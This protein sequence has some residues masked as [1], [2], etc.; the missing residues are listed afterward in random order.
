MWDG[1]FYKF[2]L[3]KQRLFFVFL[4]LVCAVGNAQTRYFKCT[5]LSG[6]TYNWT[7]VGNWY[8]D[9]TCTT[10]VAGTV[11]IPVSTSDVVFNSNCFTA[12][13][14]TINLDGSGG[15]SSKGFT[16]SYAGTYTNAGVVSIQGNVL[17]VFGDIDLRSFDNTKL[18][19]LGLNNDVVINP[20]VKGTIDIFTGSKALYLNSISIPGDPVTNTVNFND[21]LYLNKKSIGGTANRGVIFI[22][23]GSYTSNTAIN[24]NFKD[25]VKLGYLPGGYNAG[26]EI[27]SGTVNF[28]N[29]LISTAPIF[30]V[31]T[32]YLSKSASGVY[33]GS[34]GGLYIAN[35][36]SVTLLPQTI[37]VPARNRNQ[38]G[39]LEVGGP[40]VGN[41]P[42]LNASNQTLIIG[43]FSRLG[44]ARVDFSNNLLNVNNYVG[45]NP[46]GDVGGWFTTT[47]T[48]LAL[49]GSTL[50]LAPNGNNLGFAYGRIAANFSAG[51]TYDI[52]NLFDNTNLSSL[53]G[54]TNFK[55][56]NVLAP[57]K[58]INISGTCFANIVAGGNVFLERGTTI[59]SPL[60]LG[61]ATSTLSILNFS[62]A[63]T[64]TLTMVGTCAQ[65]IFLNNTTFIFG[66]MPLTNIVADYL[67]LDDCQA[68]GSNVPYTPGA[69]LRRIY[70]KISTGWGVSCLP[71]PRT[72]Y[73]QG[74]LNG[75]NWSDFNNWSLVAGASPSSTQT[76]V[77][78][79]SCLPTESD[80]LVFPNLSNVILN[81]LAH[82]S[83]SVN[84]VNTATIS[85][86]SGSNPNIVWNIY[87][88]WWATNKLKN[89][90]NGQIAFKTYKQNRLIKTGGV[91]FG[92][93]GGMSDYVLKFN[94]T[95]PPNGLCVPTTSVACGGWI[96][97]DTLAVDVPLATFFY[98]VFTKAIAIQNGIF[99]TYDPNPLYSSFFPATQKKGSTIFTRANTGLYIPNT[100]VAYDSVKLYDSDIYL[101]MGSLG[102]GDGLYISKQNAQLMEGTAEFIAMNGILRLP[103]IGNKI[104]ELT[105]KTF[106]IVSGPFNQVNVQNIA[107][108]NPSYTDLYMDNDTI[109]KTTN[110]QSF[111]I[112]TQSNV[113]TGFIHRLVSTNSN[114]ST[115]LTIRADTYNTNLTTDSLITN[116]N[117]NIVNLDN[118]KTINVLVRNLFHIYSGGVTLKM[119]NLNASQFD[120][121]ATITFT[122]G[123]SFISAGSCNNRNLIRSNS[124]LGTPTIFSK[125]NLLGAITQ[126]VTATD[127]QDN[128]VTGGFGTLNT[129]GST[130]GTTTGWSVTSSPPRLL[131]WANGLLAG[132]TTLDWSSIQRW[133]KAITGNTSLA[134][135]PLLT[136]SAVGE[137]P[138]TCQDTVLVD[139]ASFSGVSDSIL[140]NTPN[141]QAQ[142][143]KFYWVT[144][145]GFP[146]FGGLG[147]AVLSVCDSLYFSPNMANRFRGDIVF[148]GNPVIAGNYGIKNANKPF[149]GRVVVDC[150][151]AN[152]TYHLRD[153][154]TGSYDNR[155]IFNPS[156]DLASLFHN[157]G[158]LNTHGNNL[159]LVR[160]SSAGNFNRKLIADGSVIRLSG[161]I[162]WNPGH[163]TAAWIVAN[164]G[165]TKTY[166]ISTKNTRFVIKAD[167]YASG[168]GVSTTGSGMIGGGYN[169][170]NVDF[171]STSPWA[172]SFGYLAGGYSTIYYSGY[173]PNSPS[174]V[175]T[176]NVINNNILV[177]YV[178]TSKLAIGPTSVYGDLPVATMR[179]KT[180]NSNTSALDILGTSVHVDS[181]EFLFRTNSIVTSYN[182]NSN[183]HVYKHWGL[184]AVTAPQLVNLASGSV[185]WLHNQCDFRPFG[186]NTNKVNLF[187]SGP[188]FNAFIR[189]DSGRVCADWLIMRDLWA[190]GSGSSTG[191]V[192][193]GS[194][195]MC[196]LPG[197]SFKC[198]WDTL[199]TF[200]GNGSTA[201][202]TGSGYGPVTAVSPIDPNYTTSNRAWFQGG[203]GTDFQGVNN[204]GWEKRNTE[205]D[206]KLTLGKDTAICEGDTAQIRFAIEGVIP[207]NVAFNKNINGPSYPLGS[208]IPLFINIAAPSS[209]T[210]TPAS[211]TYINSTNPTG[212]L[213]YLVPTNGVALNAGEPTNPFVLS[214]KVSPTVTTQYN[215]GSLTT[216]KCRNNTT[217]TITATGVANVT[218]N[219]IP[220]NLASTSTPS[221]VC[222]GLS[223]ITFTGSTT[224]GQ[225]YSLYPTPTGTLGSISMISYTAGALTNA[226]VTIAAN[227]FTTASSATTFTYY[228]SAQSDKGCKSSPR[229]PITVT[230]NP[231][232]LVAASTQ[233]NVS[234]YVAN[235][236]AASVTISN[237]TPIYTYT[238]TSSTSTINTATGLSPGT[239]TV[240]STDTKGCSV[241]QSFSIS[242]PTSALAIQSSAS[243]SIACFGASTG[244]A[245]VIANGG[246]GAYTYSWT[247]NASVANT[248][249]GLSAGNYTV[250]VKDLNSCMVS[251]TFALNQ[252]TSAV[253]VSSS[254]TASVTCY[255]ASTGSASV[256]VIGGV[257]SYTYSW[258]SGI[259]STTNT[260]NG[261]GTGNYTVTVSDMNGCV[262]TKSLAITQPLAT[263]VT[264][265][266]TT[267]ANCGVN[268]GAANLSVAGGSPAFTYSWTPPSPAAS[269]TTSSAITASLG[270]GLNQLIII[271]ANGCTT[272]TVITI[273]NP[274]SPL[275]N[276]SVTTIL[277][278]GNLTGAV[279]TTVSNG[280]PTYSYN[281]SNGSTTSALTN[282]GAGN[283]T[284]T[285]TDASN[286]K[287]VTT[288][289]ITQPASAVT[290]QTASSYS[291]GCY[292]ASTGSAQVTVTGG[293]PSYTYS[294]TG[295]ITS[296][297]N[298][299]VGLVAGNYSVTVKDLNNCPVTQS[300][301]IAQPTS[302]LNISSSSAS[303][304]CY[305]ASTGSATI[306]VTG[307]T[308]PYTYSWIGATSST[309]NNAT[310]LTVGNYNV[311]IK[312][313]NNCSI[314]HTF[315]INQPASALNITTSSSASIACY[316]ASTGS[317][318]IN[319]TG[320]T[321]T[322]SYTWT[323]ATSSTT[324][325]ATA[326]IAGNYSVVVNDL[327]NCVVSQTFIISQPADLVVTVT[328][329][330]QASCG[331]NNGSASVLATGGI[332][333]Y[334]YSWTPPLPALS[335]STNTGGTSALGSGTTQLVV[336]DANGCTETQQIFITNPNLPVINAT[337][338]DVNCYGN[339]TGV[340]TTTV[341]NGTP[342][343][344][345]TWSNGAV[346]SSVTNLIAG[347]YTLT[348]ID[349]SYC[350]AV[351]TITVT[352]PTTPLSVT[353][354]TVTPVYCFGDS[355]G[356]ANALASGGTSSYTYTWQPGNRLGSNLNQVPTGTY[357]VIVTDLLGCISNT[358]A[359]IDGTKTPVLATFVSSVQAFCEQT[360]GSITIMATGG[361]PQYSYQWLKST[362]TTPTLGE[363][364]AGN[365][366]VIVSDLYNCKDTLTVT[367]NCRMD[368]YIPQLFSPNGDGKND[369]LVITS[370]EYYPNNTV[371]IFN[372]W[373]SLVYTKKHYLN[374]WQGTS[375][376]GTI[377][378]NE[379]LPAGTY[380]ILVDFGDKV[381]KPYNGFVE[382]RY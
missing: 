274:N 22:G 143:G 268:N 216:G 97:L 291:I 332:P 88:G 377:S 352:Q 271:D 4:F 84:F 337:A 6:S 82:Y 120:N 174:V 354:N 17:N 179:A 203:T 206:P 199:S 317:A 59:S 223:A 253:S 134:G 7:S 65:T 166:S 189:K 247:G 77:S 234:C 43:G 371:T 375:N 339:Q 362:I 230:V 261:L 276:A 264:V 256:N 19:I 329:T 198:D 93:P 319:V 251:Q 40:S 158:T 171:Y 60:T 118:T 177:G 176:F 263:T 138:P 170:N 122:P 200:D 242:Q 117:T 129:D 346:N 151:N 273:T 330:T 232:P 9:V 361:S 110:F 184:Y 196:S 32:N 260:A 149:V 75:G 178:A 301:S 108:T 380:Y 296:V 1:H 89:Q 292:G 369:N 8:S 67:I 307:G 370:I 105:I 254:S 335:F 131:H 220:R 305:G 318:T 353:I 266:S 96:V 98:N 50:N 303:V 341:T 321:P 289:T 142:V 128:I 221:M 132:S 91:P 11:G 218:V 2:I 125:F 219:P 53:G 106:S 39:C 334:T 139:N 345:Y 109:T 269:Y 250:T 306:N 81:N 374:E 259:S 10:P 187:S 153:S 226:S 169:Y 147:T 66:T 248:A 338:T 30:S 236:G 162:L 217:T 21:S 154:L 359:L 349:A 201:F 146:G 157:K 71:P 63:P 37:G 314:T 299:V 31:S 300:F 152:S 14:Q 25:L 52:V 18:S 376:A 123:S 36:S 94:A 133:Q 257:P 288:L 26:I 347:T 205:A 228:L 373:G 41:S 80:S 116:N 382:L 297:T 58:F 293:V 35:S 246:T 343:Y 312:D 33:Y 279:T 42:T 79:G 27:N 3:K 57:N 213:Y 243:N 367:L 278:Y 74:P 193:S 323:G 212:Y 186:N 156:N 38:I 44:I 342:A 172:S 298:S 311:T 78:I 277:C 281:W 309:T 372:R 235:N 47:T 167:A 333:S 325:N 295:G 90:Y 237:G 363:I 241:T 208:N 358:T 331:L 175:D 209:Y 73:W 285:V 190:V 136:W 85:I 62:F 160:Y 112:F 302:G 51:H 344:S 29:G 239:Y 348:V 284:L 121:N 322:Y 282:V 127:V 275:V 365:Y 304:A 249:L 20:T 92:G 262:I 113:S 252:P 185:Q 45:A 357:T 70:G 141:Y 192:A 23:T 180:I 320:G 327:N 194:S 103:T 101:N 56:I 148:K 286:C 140:I 72:V 137:C 233:S 114:P 28:N 308:L 204:R 76:P 315:V 364:S 245:Q 368:L 378:G 255:G 207:F 328:A 55:Q 115:E 130:L 280:T 202:G 270:V 24:V 168:L 13:N 336:I 111:R 224:N 15:M 182:L 222:S 229:V 69:N 49:T 381:T 356:F 144:T 16:I 272:S 83:G 211:A 351:K 104:D 34:N 46:Y 145:A 5:V 54:T 61:P 159:N 99:K 119:G 310:A 195:T 86:P 124:S 183:N 48:T 126:I 231:L 165:A 267:P 100:N 240:T 244:S 87:G 238:W 135:M 324:N 316:G 173:N 197:M 379:K 355:T 163:L 210:Q 360:N 95:Q 313:L 258:S 155:V 12:N 102:T 283:Y 265:V 290:I 214:I 227:S 68:T 188:G 340:I 150:Y 225:V 164:H 181:L 107:Q 161:N 287:A 350:K 191:P 366:T 294:W 64:A 326:L 215:L